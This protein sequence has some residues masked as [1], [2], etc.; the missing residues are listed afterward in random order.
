MRSHRV[1]VSPP[2]LNDDLCL[3]KAVE[4]LP[5]EQFIPEPCVE[6]LAISVFPRLVLLLRTQLFG[7]KGADVRQFLEI[8]FR[9]NAGMRFCWNWHVKFHGTRRTGLVLCRRE[10]KTTEPLFPELTP[11]ASR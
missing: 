4:D 5:V 7:P 6:T 10:C 8:C 2:L 1:V 11:S 3:F 9:D